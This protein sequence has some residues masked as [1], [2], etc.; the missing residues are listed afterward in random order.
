MLLIACD[1]NGSKMEQVNF[2]AISSL[3]DW[4]FIQSKTTEINSDGRVYVFTNT[5]GV[6]NNDQFYNGSITPLFD[7]LKS[8][9]FQNIVLL[10]DST[11][12]M[13]NNPIST[14]DFIEGNYNEDEDLYHTFKRFMN[15]KE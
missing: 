13:E 15:K 11:M 2:L 9:L 7:Q 14:P 6:F 3:T 10:S 1:L 12:R 4:K 8:S 5:A